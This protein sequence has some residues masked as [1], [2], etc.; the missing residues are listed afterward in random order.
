VVAA[1]RLFTTLHQ[2]YKMKLTYTLTALFMSV[3]TF[4]Q[5]SEC[6]SVAEA[7]KDPAKVISLKMNSYMSDEAFEGFPP[8][9]FSFVN[10]EELYLT[11]FEFTEIPAAIGKLTKLK[12]LSFAGNSLEKLPEEIFEL[13]NLKELLLNNNEFSDEYKAYIKKTAKEKL[14]NTKLMIN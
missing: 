14:P 2:K 8:V 4:A 1:C 5:C 3:L 13:K 11:D 10:I 12:T 6:K 7:E 9:I